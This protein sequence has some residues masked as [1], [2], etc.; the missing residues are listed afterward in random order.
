MIGDKVLVE[1]REKGGGK[2]AEEGRK[3][4]NFKRGLRTKNV[5]VPPGKARICEVGNDITL[6]GISNMVPECLRA[7]E[8]LVEK[9]I[10]VEVID[11]IWLMPLDMGS[12]LNSVVKTE[13]LFQT[14]TLV[15]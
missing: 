9:G 13:Y 10:S 3:S 2:E 4:R 14:K 5:S 15:R 12:I 7:R 8:L 11:P 1:R 6:V